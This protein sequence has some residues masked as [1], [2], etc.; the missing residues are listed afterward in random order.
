[1]IDKEFVVGLDLGTTN[2]K[3]LLFSLTG[4]VIAEK[5]ERVETIFLEGEGAEQDAREVETKALNCLRGIIQESKKRSGKIVAIGL[6]CAM[7]SLIFVEER[8]EPLGNML[9][10]SDGRAAEKAEELLQDVGREIYSRT[11]T[12]IHPMNPFVK[13]CWLQ[14][15][16]PA[17]LNNAA[18]IMTMKD[19]LVSRWFGNR[20]IDYSM[21][22]S[23]GLFNLN[24]Y[25][26]DEEALA[27]VNIKRE[28]LSTPVPPH[29][30]LPE[31][32]REIAT[33]IGLERNIPFVIGAAD[34]QLANLGSGAIAETDVAIS[35]GTSG[36]VRKF[37]NGTAL[38]DKM[39]TFCYP[40][41]K[42]TTIIGGPTNN[43]GIVLQWLKEI[44][45]IAEDFAAFLEMANQVPPGSEGVL[46][47]PYINGERAPLW[48]QVAK[49]TF[50]GLNVSHQKEHLIRAALEGISFNLYQIAQTL[51]AGNTGEETILVSG[52]FARSRVWL[53]ILADI[54]GKRIALPTTPQSSAWGA[55]WCALV[56]IG[57]VADFHE[58]K[59]HIV[60]S[61]VIEPDRERHETYKERYALYEK[62]CKD[63]QRYF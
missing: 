4:Q 8:L 62:L 16:K 58:I 48:K 22:A 12:P 25:D 19:Y 9:L 10:W 59:K 20:Y 51:P 45:G 40:F 28:K 61:D 60:I 52:G 35:V 63:V 49:G 41:T 44:L 15:Q 6:S 27:F 26:W 56:G 23:M 43:G 39:R 34:G 7:H 5:E 55:A 32:R 21:A 13:L 54:F 3:A 53:Q 11:G 30:V 29:F 14:K 42:E 47:L 38:D 57:K 31:L 33:E 36:A 18:F 17:L 2:V 24:T 46:F 50:F 1:M 37:I